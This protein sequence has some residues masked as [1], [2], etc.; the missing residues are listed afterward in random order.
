MYF[1]QHSSI[2]DP[3]AHRLLANSKGNFILSIAVKPQKKKE[4]AL[5][6]CPTLP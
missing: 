2:S 5:A 3:V 6:I 4:D 1:R